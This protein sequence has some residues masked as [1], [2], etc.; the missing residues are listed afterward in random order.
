MSKR[1]TCVIAEDTRTGNSR[2]MER[3]GERPSHLQAAREYPTQCAL[4]EKRS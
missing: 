4:P 2:S 3:A 1:P